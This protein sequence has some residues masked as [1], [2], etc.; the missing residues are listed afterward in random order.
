MADSDV[1]EDGE[2]EKVVVVRRCKLESDDSA[3]SKKTACKPV[4]ILSNMG[5]GN[6]PLW[7][8]QT[9]LESLVLTLTGT[10]TAGTFSSG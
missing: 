10:V 7:P 1:D 9:N 3:V 5:N 4:V 2:D 8:K 6:E